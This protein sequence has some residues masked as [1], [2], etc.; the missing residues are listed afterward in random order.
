MPAPDGAWRRPPRVGTLACPIGGAQ[1]PDAVGGEIGAVRTARTPGM[2]Q[3]GAAVDGDDTRVRVRRTAAH[4]VSSRGGRHGRRRNNGG[5]G[6]A[7]AG[8][9]DPPHRLPIANFSTTIGSATACRTAVEYG[10]KAICRAGG[11][12]HLVATSP[13]VAQT[14][15]ARARPRAASRRTRACRSAGH[16]HRYGP[17]RLDQGLRAARSSRRGRHG[18]AVLSGRR[19]R[20]EKRRSSAARRTRR[21]RPIP[22]RHP[23]RHRRLRRPRASR[24]GARR[25]RPSAFDPGTDELRAP[26]AGPAKAAGHA[27]GWASRGRRRGAC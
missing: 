7:R 23:A 19:S 9:L 14:E 17:R 21:P 20:K 10:H 16:A 24:A 22:H 2:C 27:G 3:R 11:R 6:P 18:A 12:H 4:R 5:R 1:S 25:C 8:V 13:A 26:L 15:R